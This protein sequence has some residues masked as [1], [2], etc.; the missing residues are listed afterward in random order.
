[1]EI[2]EL[3]RYSLSDKEKYISDMAN[4]LLHTFFQSYKIRYVEFHSQPSNNPNGY[5]VIYIENMGYTLLNGDG[6]KGLGWIKDGINIYEN[7]N[8]N[9]VMVRFKDIKNIE[10]CDWN[11]IAFISEF[12]KFLDYLFEKVFNLQFTSADF[13]E[14]LRI[15]GDCNLLWQ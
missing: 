11:K 9:F 12:E 3:L 1:M 10:D 4:Q 8:N 7:V 2:M 6:D 14:K 15:I 13:K 5:R